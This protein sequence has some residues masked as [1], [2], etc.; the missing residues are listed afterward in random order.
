ME[1]GKIKTYWNE[2]WVKVETKVPTRETDYYV[3]NYGKIKSVNKKT[4]AER[5]LKGTKSKNN[6]LMLNLKLKDNVRQGFYVHKL[7][8]TY[9]LERPSEAHKFLVHLD[10]DRLNNHFKNLKW[11]TRDELSERWRKLEIYSTD[12]YLTHPNTKMTQS[13]VRLLKQRLEKGK[14]KKKILAKQFNISV[15]QVNRIESGENWG[16]IKIGE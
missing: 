5:A 14:T 2:V 1:N 3:S 11:L 12:M 10:R 8:G 13:K 6:Y 7:V 4:G 9:F 15:T 16:H